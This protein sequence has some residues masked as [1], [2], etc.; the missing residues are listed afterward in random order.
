MRDVDRPG[1]RDER[2]AAT[3]ERARAREATRDGE[4]RTAGASGCSGT[5]RATSLDA[6]EEKRRDAR[7]VRVVLGRGQGAAKTSDARAREGARARREGARAVK[8][9]PV[10][11][12]KD[13]RTGASAVWWRDAFAVSAALDGDDGRSGGGERGERPRTRRASDVVFRARHES[14]VVA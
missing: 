1:G 7:G 4:R 6:A 11:F 12:D 9:L 8:S 2:A 5:S 3:P 10:F 14:G 13:G